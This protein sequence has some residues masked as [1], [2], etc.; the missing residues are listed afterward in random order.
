MNLGRML[1]END[2]LREAF[3]IAT[4]ITADS[5]VGINACDGLSRE[6]IEQK[7][8]ENREAQRKLLN[9]R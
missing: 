6:E 9:G 2:D 7:L 4:Q 3:S 1:E 8:R 5:R